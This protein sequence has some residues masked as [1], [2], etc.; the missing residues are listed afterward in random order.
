MESVFTDARIETAG[1]C[2]TSGASDA[3]RPA[4]A[5]CTDRI[6]SGMSDIATLLLLTCAA[7][8]SAVSVT[9][10]KTQSASC[11]CLYVL[12]QRAFTAAGGPPRRPDRQ[13]VVEGK[14]V[15]LP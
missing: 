15:S 12:I 4:R 1:S 2:L 3:P 11:N 7:T 9:R 10:V 5:S 8:I 13:S 14:R 6:T